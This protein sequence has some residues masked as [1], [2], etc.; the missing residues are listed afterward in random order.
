MLF[1]ASTLES[2]GFARKNYQMLG[3][4]RGCHSL[5]TELLLLWDRGI[6]TEHSGLGNDDVEP[7]DSCVF[8]VKRQYGS[9]SSIV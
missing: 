2:I 3:I 1:V 6:D 8:I 4:V 7:F 9:S 5:E